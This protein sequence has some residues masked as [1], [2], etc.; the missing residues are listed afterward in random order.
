VDTLRPTIKITSNKT[1]IYPDEIATISFTMSEQST[2]FVQ[3]DV[4]VSGATLTS[5]A[6]SGALYFGTIKP[7]ASSTSSIV[8][9]VNDNKF[10]D[11]A[12]NLNKNS[13]NADNAVSIAL[14]SFRT[15]LVTVLVDK[16][17]LG[18]TPVLLKDLVEEITTIGTTVASQTMSYQGT[19]FKYS[20]IDALITTVTR[21]SEFTEEF[22]KEIA[23]QYPTVG[24]ITYKEA[25]SLVGAASIDSILIGV[26]GADGNYIG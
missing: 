16:G 23:D 2:D 17:V 13:T 14:A 25:V 15:H 20:D 5:F 24:N 12:G 11:A 1:A 9:A 3:T 8:V 4:T 26:A 6:G 22:R 7:V 19:K 10:S 18:S 21:D